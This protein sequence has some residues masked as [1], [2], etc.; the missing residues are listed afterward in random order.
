MSYYAETLLFDQLQYRSTLWCTEQ[1]SCPEIISR[2]LHLVLIDARIFAWVKT[3]F[4]IKPEK[5]NITKSKLI[6]L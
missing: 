6:C 5:Y 2:K 1:R 4:S 3:S